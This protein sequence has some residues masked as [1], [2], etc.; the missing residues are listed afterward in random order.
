MPPKQPQPLGNMFNNKA[1]Q[2]PLLGGLTAAN[3]VVGKQY[4]AM[5]KSYQ[6]PTFTPGFSK[7][8]NFSTNVANTALQPGTKILKPALQKAGVPAGIAGVAGTIG[9]VA[10][11][12]DDDFALVARRAAE[13][14][15]IHPSDIAVMYHYANAA[16]GGAATMSKGAEEAAEKLLQH[17]DIPDKGIGNNAKTFRDILE[18]RKSVKGTYPQD[19]DNLGR[20]K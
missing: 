16:K 4:S 17:W 6:N 10:G 1:Q 7:L 5:Q 13:L 18:G 20:F 15:H 2:S 14:P 8:L 19:R 9:D 11:L 3:N 12:P